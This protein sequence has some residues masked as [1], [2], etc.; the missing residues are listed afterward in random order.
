MKT[1][2]KS[3]QNIPHHTPF[4]L[5]EGLTFRVSQGV[6]GSVKPSLSPLK[7]QLCVL[8]VIEVLEVPEVSTGLVAFPIKEHKTNKRIVL[9]AAYGL[10]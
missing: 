6:M 8:E 3:R 1:T 7:G 5:Q 2:S 9:L 10:A 4:S